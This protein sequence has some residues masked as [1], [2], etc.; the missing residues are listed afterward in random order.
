MSKSEFDK[1]ESVQQFAEGLASQTNADVVTQ[2]AALE[3]EEK[4]LDL[5]IK[6][7]QVAKIKSQR[8]AKLDENRAKQIATKQF[9]ANR[10]ANQEHCNHRKGGSGAGAVINGEGTDQNYAVIKHKMPNGTYSI[11]CQRCGREWHAPFPKLGIEGSKD[12]RW[13]LNLPSDNVPSGSSTFLFERTEA[14]VA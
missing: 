7:E 1:T 12:Y 14:A 4:Q 3:L 6:R 11:F 10:E 8:N 5:E 13:A 9:L 2:L